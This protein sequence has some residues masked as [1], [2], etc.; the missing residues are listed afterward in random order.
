MRAATELKAVFLKAMSMK[1][2]VLMAGLLLS[3]ALLAAEKI[4]PDVV[5]L[6]AQLDQIDAD[7]SLASLAGLERLKARQALAA[8]RQAK[9]RDRSHT[10][11]VAERRVEAAEQ[12]AQAELLAAQAMQLDREYD[13]LQLDAS[14]REA[15]R[16]RRDAERLR[17]QSLARAEEAERLLDAERTAREQSQTEAAA[18]SAEAAQARK[19][20]AARAREAE[21]ARQEADL[22][23]AVMAEAS[24]DAPLPPKREE[25]GRTVYTL[26]GNA[27]AS[28]KAGLTATARAS[29]RSLGALLAARQGDIRIT[30]HSDSQGK[31]SANLA[32]SQ[33]RAEAVQQALAE[34]GVA[35][36]RMQALGRGQ[37]EPVADNATNDGRAQNRRV[38]ISVK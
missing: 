30:G 22:T 6:Q 14:R 38:E 32:L 24:G 19:L 7:P 27:F 18:A 20:A 31:A 8:L 2:G 16:A 29:L 21:L 11:F 1:A 13:Q 34:G 35:S 4:D 12:M 3:G 15:E 28:G 26:A 23:A 33:Q 36:S 5:R 17:L 10:L 37:E 9:S 25:A